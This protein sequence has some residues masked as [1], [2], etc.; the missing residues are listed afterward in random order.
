M[1][2]LNC[3][4]SSFGKL[5]NFSY[6]FSDGLNTIIEDNGWGK[7]TFATFI[8]A[9]FYGINSTKRSVAE[10]ERIKYKPWN[11]TQRFGGYIEFLWGDNHYKIERFFGAKEAEDTV[12][13]FDVKTGKE[14]TNTENLGKRIFEIDEDGFLST[15]YF[16]QKDFEIKSNSSLTAKFNSVCDVQNTEAFDKALLKLEDKAKTYKY[17]GDKGLIADTKREIADIDYEIERTI[18]S[19]QTASLIKTEVVALEKEVDQLKQTTSK[20]TEQ[21]AKA[22]ELEGLKAKKVHYDQLL[23]DRNQMILQLDKS[24]KILNGNDISRDDVN[25]FLV[26]NQDLLTASTNVKIL[27]SDIENLKNTTE[28]KPKQNKKFNLLLILPLFLILAG[29]GCMA[30][31]AI[32]LGIILLAV[33]I[34]LATVLLAIKNKSSKE[35]PAT[36]LS[37]I[38]NEKQTQLNKYLELEK[39]ISNRIDSFIA[40]FNVGGYQDRY[41]ALSL[42][43]NAIAEKE[44]L[45]E[46]LN[47]IEQKIIDLNVNKDNFE[48][49]KDCTLDITLIKNQLQNYQ[50]E[51]TRKSSLLADKRASLLTHENYANTIIDLQSKREDLT[52]QLQAYVENYKVLTATIDYLKTAD[53][54]LKVKYRAPLQNSLNKYLTL[55]T[56][57][58]IKAQ[59]DI[60]LVVSV[61]EVDG[62]KS[63]DYYSKGYQN[64]FEICKRFALTDVLFTKEK[65]FIILDDPFYNLDDKKITQAI[66]LIESLSKEYQI[67]YFVCHQSRA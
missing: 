42:I 2:L 61:E 40:R 30:F 46:T 44:K 67:I 59:I 45:T 57:S 16:S 26:C 62:R 7:S 54:T 52:Q 49:I 17:R 36:N 23:A 4:I 6:N 33:S 18:K 58:D 11:S 12:R 25:N 48:K 50:L 41:F 37:E 63:T 56:E 32:I 53:Q 43:I 31:N 38:I 20:L 1:K 64:L 51:Y 22:S 55:I 66:K 19:A 28:N 9:M 65:P 14:F 29:I 34:V 3:Y 24:K 47:S 10:N 35:Q 13:L 15:T 39:E 60:D 27:S 5:Q 21:V 8:K